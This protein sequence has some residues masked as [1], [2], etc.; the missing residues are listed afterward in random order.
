MKK[1]IT[2]KHAI[3]ALKKKSWYTR[4]NGIMLAILILLIAAVL[5]KAPAAMRDDRENRTMMHARYML[6]ALSIYYGGHMGVWP[7][8]LSDLVPANIEQILPEEFTGKN[9]VTVINEPVEADLKSDAEPAFI[10]GE[11]GWIY[12][13]SN[14][15]FFL[16]IKGKDSK[17]RPYWKYGH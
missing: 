12:V 1:K 2:T 5:I 3:K 17:G 6:N 11:G 9:T 14:G 4:E 13:P 8:A 16:N 15:G 10:N 7:S